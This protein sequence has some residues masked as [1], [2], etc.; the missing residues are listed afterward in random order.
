M[1]LLGRITTGLAANLS[2]APERTGV[3]I[4][5]TSAHPTPEQVADAL[6]AK[7]QFSQADRAA[8]KEANGGGDIREQLIAELRKRGINS[9]ALTYVGGGKYRGYVGLSKQTQQRLIAWSRT[10]GR[11]PVE[12]T[13][14]RS[15]KQEELQA[16]GA[17]ARHRAELALRKQEAKQ[18]VVTNIVGAGGAQV[19]GATLARNLPKAAPLLAE[20]LPPLALGTSLVASMAVTLDKGLELSVEQQMEVIRNAPPMMS[21]KQEERPPVDTTQQPSAPA[22]PSDEEL[23]KGELVPTGDTTPPTS[24]PPTTSQPTNTQPTVPQSQPPSSNPLGKL[25]GPAIGATTTA[26]GIGANKAMKSKESLAVHDTRARDADGI[27]DVDYKGQPYSAGQKQ[28]VNS[29]GIDPRRGFRLE[30][31]E[32]G[33]ASEEQHN[34][35]LTR[36]QGEG[37]EFVDQHGRHWDVASPPSISKSGK[38]IF[39]VD[40]AMNSIKSHLLKG[41]VILDFGRLNDAD[42]ATLKKAVGS[43]SEAERKGRTIITVRDGG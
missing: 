42:A 17:L 37:L 20:A 30:E 25:V 10:D 36:Y 21:E 34:L 6:L 22:V 43:L 11:A 15:I 38:P 31:G 16:Q 2:N 18:Q 40:Q 12:A 27:P 26:A 4:E 3:M 7:L 32:A 14:S 1:S 33:L 29:L 19:A 9:A 35:S 39:R 5:V 23:P 24:S 41:N 8:L 28:R 13:T